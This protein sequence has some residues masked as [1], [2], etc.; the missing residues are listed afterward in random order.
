MFLLIK[1]YI[2]E[3]HL[4]FDLIKENYETSAESDSW[5]GLVIYK[6]IIY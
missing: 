2:H 6:K 1:Y 4:G 3:K 5:V